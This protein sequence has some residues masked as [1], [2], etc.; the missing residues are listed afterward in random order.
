MSR[1][2]E[3]LLT[4]DIEFMA[5]TSLEVMSLEML[6]T[7]LSSSC[8][9]FCFSSSSKT[10]SVSSSFWFCK[11][12]NFPL[13]LSSCL[14]SDRSEYSSFLSP[15]DTA[16]KQIAQGYS[17]YAGPMPKSW[18]YLTTYPYGEKRK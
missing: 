8:L 14:I 13:P 18:V 6:I 7:T 4:F 16:Q 9:G 1:N 15:D 17:L 3:I 12:T 2:L 5:E 11:V 10:T